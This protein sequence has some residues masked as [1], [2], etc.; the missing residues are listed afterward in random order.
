MEWW[1]CG[2]MG[3]K[4]R[5]SMHLFCI[6]FHILMGYFLGQKQKIYDW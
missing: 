2:M 6:A 1:N 4:K 5:V 3:L